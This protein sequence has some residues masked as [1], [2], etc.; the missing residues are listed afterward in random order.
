MDK[1]GDNSKVEKELLEKYKK[2]LQ[3]FFNELRRDITLRSSNIMQNFLSIDKR[4]EFELDVKAIKKQPLIRDVTDIKL[5]EGEFSNELTLHKLRLTKQ[6][7]LHVPKTIA[8]Y[9]EL[10]QATDETCQ[11]MRLLSNSY[12]KN[13]RILKELGIVYA[14]IEVSLRFVQVIVYRTGRC[15]QYIK[16]ESTSHV[17]LL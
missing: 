6:I 7:S 13:A 9:Q 11:I 2:W 10:I 16:L 14:N 15:I 4:S 17:Q 1:R 3:R 5:L 12:D 8:L